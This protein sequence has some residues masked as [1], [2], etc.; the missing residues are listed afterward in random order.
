MQTFN[1][2]AGL[3]RYLQQARLEKAAIGFVP[4]MGA[5][6]DGHIALIQTAVRENDLTVCSIFVNPVQFNNPDDLQKY[7]RTLEADSLQLQEAGCDVLFAP[8]VTEMYPQAPIVSFGFGPL[9]TVMEGTFRPGHFSGVGI[10]VAK[11]FNIVEPDKA[12]FGQKDLQQ[13]AVVRALVRDLSFPVDIRICPTLRE[14]DGLAMSSRNTR[15]TAQER[16][17]APQLFQVLKTCKKELLAGIPVETAR[18]HADAAFAAMEGFRLEYLEIVDAVS[19]QPLTRRGAPET[20]A[21]CVAAY[22]GEVRLIDNLV[23]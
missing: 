1:T 6:H 14:S 12:Y 7:P 23:F 3:R 19:L 16:T 15:L 4:T 20:T 18:Q 9:E 10:V 11:L 5:L 22:L 8:E 13:T 17:I 2:V 21:I